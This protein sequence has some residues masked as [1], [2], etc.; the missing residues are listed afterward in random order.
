MNKAFTFIVV[1]A[2][3][4]G[5]SVPLVSQAQVQEG[6]IVMNT[7]PSYPKPGETVTVSLSTFSLDLDKAYIIW[8]LNGE[9][10]ADGIGKSNFSFQMDSLG[11]QITL[12]ADIDTVSGQTITKTILLSATELD[13]LWEAVDAYTPPFYKGKTLV[14]K[15]GQ[16]KVVAVPSILQTTG[17]ISPNNLTYTWRKDGKG[18]VSAS[19]FGKSSFTF[20]NSYLDSQH[21]IEV[22]VSDI[23]GRTSTGGF[24]NL[25][26]VT[27][28]SIY[29]YEKHPILGLQ[30]QKT[31]DVGFLVPEEGSTIVAAPYF[32]SPKNID[33]LSF[34]WVVGDSP[35]ATPQIKNELAVK[36]PEGESGSTVIDIVIENTKSLFQ[37]AQKS[38]N[39]AF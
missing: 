23:E 35:V 32:F 36:G 28:P 10:R 26:P 5:V 34:R 31:L 9:Q 20:K 29:F 6:D 18:Q 2:L 12:S 21:E 16:Y 33:D 4:F 30:M 19:G 38:L 27:S 37:N 39:V 7:S 1:L 8:S 15:E 11:S 13:L 14:T 25:I 17:K 3:F 24:I 22:S